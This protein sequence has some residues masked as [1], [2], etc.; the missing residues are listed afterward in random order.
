MQ[1]VAGILVG[2]TVAHTRSKESEAG[3]DQH[4][5]DTLDDS[6]ARVAHESPSSVPFSIA[7]L[8]A[9]ICKASMASQ[10]C[11]PTPPASPTPRP[12]PWPSSAW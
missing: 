11:P 12:H 8:A 9:S 1:P 7:I 6:S 3:Y 5:G 10:A 2:L 4:G